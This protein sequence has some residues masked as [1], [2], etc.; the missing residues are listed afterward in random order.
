MY[1]EQ[2]KN[3]RHIFSELKTSSIK[4]ERF[5]M[6]ITKLKTE[7]KDG[8]VNKQEVVLVLDN[9][10]QISGFIVSFDESG[11]FSSIDIPVNIE[12]L[13]KEFE[14]K[15]I[16]DLINK[17]SM[18][19]QA[20]PEAFEEGSLKGSTFGRYVKEQEQKILNKEYRN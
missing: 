1:T 6:Q 11:E 3:S 12:F 14:L 2:Q 5:I 18:L 7:A 10:I 9:Y 13:D 20:A 16:A 17:L 4:Y 19:M 15:M 8:N